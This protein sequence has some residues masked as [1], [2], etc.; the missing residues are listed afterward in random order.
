MRCNSNPD[1]TR[2][3]QGSAPPDVHAEPI[4]L[5]PQCGR[6][7]TKLDTQT[8]RQVWS[9]AL[10]GAVSLFVLLGGF[11]CAADSN[12]PPGQRVFYTGHSFHVFVAPMIDQL[13]KSAG[14]R[15]HSVVGTQG[16]GDS[17]VIQHWDL[18][19]DKAT[20]RP[21]LTNGAVDV[22][23]M[24]S[25]LVLPDDGITKFTDL[26][27]AHNPKLRLLVQA[28]W[29][30]FDVASPEKRIRENAQRDGMR[31]EDLQAAVDGYRT[32]LE[33][34]IDGLN[35]A[36]G[37]PVVFIVPVGDAVVRLRSMVID[38]TFPG[39]AKQSELFTDPIG[40]G[41]GAVRAL[42]A[43]CNFVAIYRISPE[44]LRLVV[45]GVDDAQHAILQK[46][47][48]DTVSGYPRAGVALHHD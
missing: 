35:A 33:A 39:I 36:H 25:N 43:Y 40:H 15:G 29:Y 6:L 21:A 8:P 16:I 18:T 34:Q 23:T 41:G 22:F 20:A 1:V 4:P 28:S 37:Q 10:I 11:A 38:G 13:V 24:S 9:C 44:G 3:T 17:R 27:L 30:P 46:L 45:P 48:W 47:A 31:V 26:G 42:T 12:T 32:R 14:I 2:A 7:A 19:G 5:I